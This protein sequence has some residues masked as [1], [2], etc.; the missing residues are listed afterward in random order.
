[1]LGVALLLWAG[2]HN[3]RER[4]LAMQAA[5][6][7]R[8]VITKDAPGQTAAV[9]AT[10]GGENAA[11]IL[12]GKMAPGFT[13]VD[14]SGK[15][16]SLSDY[17]GRPVLVNFWATWCAPC[18]LEM[19]WFEEY[20]AKYKDQGFEVLGIAED[21]APKDEIVKTAK[22]TGVSYPVLMTD[23]K[24]ANLYGGVDSLPTSFYVDKTG[25]VV[26]ETVGLAPK[27]EVEAHIRKIIGA[28]L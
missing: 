26:E 1:V 18:K 28:G 10:G 16:V 24:V 19:P 5:N 20:R 7:N 6:A 15:K 8:V 3:L 14:L 27:D 23:N 9:G 2:W 22:R 21:D 25:T 17:K 4:R 13:L 12:R 11:T